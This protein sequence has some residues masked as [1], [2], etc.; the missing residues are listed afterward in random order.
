MHFSSEKIA[1]ILLAAFI[2]V[3]SAV[4][5]SRKVPETQFVQSA[6]NQLEDNQGTVTAF[7]S[8]TIATSLAL[9]SLPDDFASPL[10][11][12]VSDLN[13]YF[14][15]LYAVIFIEK[16]IVIEGTK[17]AL[18]WIIPIA[19]GFFI[20]SILLDKNSFKNLGTKLLVL[21]ISLVLV[22]PVSIRLTNAVCSDYMVYVEETIAE[23]SAGAGK[24]NELMTTESDTTFFERISEAFKTAI[25]GISDL[26]TYFKNV[27][28]RCVT[29]IAILMITNFALP[30][31]ILFIFR[32]LLKELF[33]F[34]LPIPQ[35]LT[36]LPR[37]PKSNAD[38]ED[39][40][41]LEIEQKDC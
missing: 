18:R 11:N 21:G 24:I 33:A 12:T 20:A 22:I 19:C 39:D 7:S 25:K 10:A 16:L 26:L 35:A 40:D 2:L 13:V 15:V 37:M 9:S 30:V 34:N 28:K 32:W 6:I 3:L 38:N 27:I 31:A 23:A 41:L 5:L 36:R 17:I 1:K 8:A 14:I 29:S 4:V